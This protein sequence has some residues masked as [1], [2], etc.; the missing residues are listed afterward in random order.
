VPAGRS[1]PNSFWKL[2]RVNVT[3]A[4]ALVDGVHH[5]LEGTEVFWPIDPGEHLKC[6]GHPPD[7]RVSGL[8]S[9]GRQRGHN[10]WKVVK[11]VA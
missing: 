8:G 5:G 4:A 3:G 6:V 9:A 11:T 10:L 2:L 1:G 7:L